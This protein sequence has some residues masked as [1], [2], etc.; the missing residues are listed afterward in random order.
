MNWKKIEKNHPKS[1]AAMCKC[2]VLDDEEY[3]GDGAYTFIYNIR[4]LYDFFD[5]NIMF[6]NVGF[7]SACWYYEIYN[8]DGADTHRTWFNDRAEAEDAAF[9]MAFK[10]L[11][12]KL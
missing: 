3:L 11:E 4:N 9:T 12:E 5:D 1:W 6:I 10:L 2:G 8:P 7:D